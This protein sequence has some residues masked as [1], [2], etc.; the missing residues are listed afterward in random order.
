MEGGGVSL[1]PQ[2]CKL[3][4]LI[5]IVYAFLPFVLFSV[6]R[7]RNPFILIKE[8]SGEKDVREII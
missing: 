2:V 1:F 8:L 7:L 3:P 5:S 4:N 6:M